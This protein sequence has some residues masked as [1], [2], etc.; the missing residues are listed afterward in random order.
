MRLRL[1]V[2][3]VA[4]LLRAV[5]GRLTEDAVNAGRTDRDIIEINLPMEPDEVAVSQ[6]VTVPGVEVLSP[7]Q[8]RR[9]L[10]DRAR[11]AA[12]LNE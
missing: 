7:K 9:D 5:P 6:L 12:E 1:P 11:A 4:D 2:D 3:Q 8:L 10:H